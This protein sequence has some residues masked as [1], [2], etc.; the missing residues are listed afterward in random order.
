MKRETPEFSPIWRR[1]RP[2]WPGPRELFAKSAG[3]RG[4]PAPLAISLVLSSPMHES[5]FLVLVPVS[6]FSLPSLS[7]TR[8]LPLLEG[9]LTTLCHYPI[10]FLLPSA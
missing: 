1:P 4:V 2:I 3:D 8:R 6:L 5:F 9:H 10:I 7:P